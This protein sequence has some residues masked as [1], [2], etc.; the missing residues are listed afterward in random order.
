MEMTAEKISVIIADDHTLFINGLC[1]LLQNEP[2]IEIMNIAANG[3]EVLGLLHTNTPNLLLLDI[4]MPGI[5]GFEVLK[6]VKSYHP[7]IKVIML[8]TY[9]E[10]HLIE[11][12]KAAGANGYLFKN[13]EKSELLKAMRLVAQGELCFPYKQP[14]TNSTFNESDPF[15]KQFQLTKREAELLQFIKQDFTNQQM[16][17]HLHL[18]IYTVETHRK[19]IMQKLNLKNPVE[20]TRFILQYDL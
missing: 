11:K 10:E 12:A 8:S 14:V 1:M 9:N 2:D 18:S 15:L 6:R 17:N 19:N 4:N 5:N 20:L 3:K 13:A 7:K 16:A